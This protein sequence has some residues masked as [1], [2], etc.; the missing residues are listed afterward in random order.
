MRVVVIARSDLV[1]RPACPIHLPDPDA[2][3]Q[4]TGPSIKPEGSGPLKA[5]VGRHASWREHEDD[6]ERLSRVV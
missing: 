6:V 5:F 1:R 2:D 4:T 3:S